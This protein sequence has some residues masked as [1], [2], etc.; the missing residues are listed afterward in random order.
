MEEEFREQ[1]SSEPATA[2]NLANENSAVSEEGSQDISLGKFKTAEALL[3]AYNNLQTEFTKKCQLLSELRKDKSE[4]NSQ[5]NLKDDQNSIEKHENIDKNQE[6]SENLVE[7]EELND[8][9]NHFLENNHE[10]KL[11]S[12]EIKSQYLVQSPFEKAWARVVFN[13]LKTSENKSDDP[14]INQYILN[15]ENIKNKIIE[16]YLNELNSSKP[17]LIISSTTGERL[18]GI[19]PDSP[20]TL[21]EAKVMVDK[22]FS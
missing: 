13:H 14:I 17:P 1:P 9:L 8:E 7:N 5:E 16:N 18:S 19:K 20:K 22:M 12:D 11:F 4:L 10:A 21:A 2:L 6:K 3:D 15:D